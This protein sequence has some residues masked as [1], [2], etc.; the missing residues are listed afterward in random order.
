MENYITSANEMNSSLVEYVNGIQVIKA[1]NQS[2]ASCE[3]Y[4]KSIDFFHDS[5]IDWGR[6]CWFWNASIGAVLPSTLL[7]TPEL[8]HPKEPV[9]LGERSYQFEDVHFGY[10]DS[11]ILH[12]ISFQ[13]V[14]GTMTAIVGP[15]GSGKSTI[16]KLMAGFW[17]VSAGDA[18]DYLSGGERQRIT[19]AR[20]MLKKSSVVILDKATA[21]A[22]PENKFLI[23]Q[24]ISKLAV[25]KTLIES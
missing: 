11:E 23:Q 13:T 18:G 2:A 10:K 8:S 19:I 9:T 12:G 21:Y 22:N 14:P 3:K 20:A 1:F 5:T 15:S 25:G 16:A 7:G 4:S 17:D 6:Q 24:A